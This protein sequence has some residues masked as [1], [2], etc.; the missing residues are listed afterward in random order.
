MGG[1]Q[2]KRWPVYGASDGRVTTLKWFPSSEGLVLRE[3][4]EQAE[5]VAEFLINDHMAQLLR[6]GA[7]RRHDRALRSIPF[8]GEAAHE[9]L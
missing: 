2:V 7:Q 3:L 8:L 1:G 9:E 5:R 6:Y 4:G